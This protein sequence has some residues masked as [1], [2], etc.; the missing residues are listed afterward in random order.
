MIIESVTVLLVAWSNAIGIQY[1][2]PTKQTKSYTFSITSGAIV[3]IVLDAPLII[4][5]GVL[6]STIAYTISEFAVTAYQLF[7]IRHQISFKLLFNNLYKYLFAGII[8]F[9]SVYLVD[10]IT[11]ISWIMIL[12]E[13]ALGACLYLL[14]IFMLKTNV[15]KVVKSM[16]GNKN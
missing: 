4:Y 3:N 10:I 16:I 7:A 14:L 12:I 6:G 1:L 8:M 2:L 11:P 13:I 5:F 15:F 9:L